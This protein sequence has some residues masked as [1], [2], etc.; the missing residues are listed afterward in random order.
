MPKKD[1]N[2]NLSRIEIS[3]DRG[4]SFSGWGVRIQRRGKGVHKFFNDKIFGG[5]R[6]AFKAASEYRDSVEA[7]LRGYSVADRAKTP[8]KR[9]TS[10][11]VGV[12]KHSQIDV[13]GEYEYH[14][15]YWIAQWTDREGKRKTKAFSI[16]EH[17]D[18]KAFKLAAAARKAGVKESG[19]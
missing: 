10:G 4:V 16:Q 13:R 1:S 15:T 9:N 8:S 17:G 7:K 3:N 12:R 14:Y 11:M 2:K 6:G 19:R 18:E 5:E